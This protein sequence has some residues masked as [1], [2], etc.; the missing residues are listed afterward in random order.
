[1]SL[2]SLLEAEDNWITD[3]GIFEAGKKIILRG[4]NLMTDLYGIQ[5][6][7]TLLLGVTGRRFDDKALQFID[8][9]WAICTSYPD[10]RI[11]NNGIAA[12]AATTR[13]LG[14]L[15]V[16]AAIAASE[17]EIYGGGP[18][19]RAYAFLMEAKMAKA[20]GENL[21]DWLMSHVRG[22][23]VMAGYGRPIVKIDERIEPAMR[24]AQEYGFDDGAHVC[25]A[26]EIHEIL[27]RT[28]YRLNINI[29]GLTAAFAADLGMS[30][31]EYRWL[32]TLAFSA[33]MLACYVDALDHTEG[34]FYPMRCKRIEYTGREIRRW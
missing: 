16:G 10:P 18:D 12:I 28:K 3:L 27:S 11:W 26:F 5:W 4:N 30:Q 34:S 8:K 29:S 23:R 6:M 14:A 24:L 33:G 2:K 9:L 21:A 19:L 7:G 22:R 25:L 13:S 32:T 15:G 20:S 17:A 1:M 31:R